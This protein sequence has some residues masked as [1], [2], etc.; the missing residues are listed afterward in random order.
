[1]MSFA[2]KPDETVAHG[3]RRIAR[4][5]IE[6]VVAGLAAKRTSP[7]AVH[8]ARKRL[9]KL[10]ALVRL[11]RDAIGEKAYRRENRCFRDAGRALSA[12]RDAAVLVDAFDKLLEHFKDHVAAGSLTSVRR[13]LL[14]RRREAMRQHGEGG[15]RTEALR[16]VRAAKQHVAKWKVGD[17][18]FAA[19]K[20]GLERMHRQ[21]RDALAEAT[22]DPAFEKLHELRKRVKDLW[23]ITQLLEPSWSEE[24][25]RSGDELH[26]L[27]DLLGDDHDLA[28]LHQT[29]QGD[30]GGEDRNGDRGFGP[31]DDLAALAALIGAR[32]RE[33][34]DAALKLAERL[35]AERPKAFVRRLAGYWDAWKTP[36]ASQPVA[37]V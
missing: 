23:H 5:E 37:P 15:G 21:G 35:Y 7:K 10:R 22:R 3:A 25:G 17:D 9:K 1:M 24:L 28:V 32:R 18:E 6:E 26:E 34:Q 20:G 19:L 36:P 4:K 31:A 11:V 2:F 14:A 30:T 33:L 16:G 8:E 29:L 12:A 13:R 27:S